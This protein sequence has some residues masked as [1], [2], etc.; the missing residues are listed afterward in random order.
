[1]NLRLVREPSRDGAT[2]GVLFVNGHFECFT[3]EDE[4]RE[5]PDPVAT[6]K[7]KGKTAIPAG[8]YPVVI[9]HSPRFGVRLPLLLNVPGFEGIRIHV[10]NRASDSEGCILPGRSRGY[11]CVGESRV[12]FGQLF[13]KLDTAIG[14]GDAVVLTIENPPGAAA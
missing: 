14:R 9:T 1:M 2:L 8:R 5:T 10:G 13:T 6:W 12:A 7:V 4:I 11:G 3:V